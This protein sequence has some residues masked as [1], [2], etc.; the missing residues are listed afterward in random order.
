MCRNE[1]C[2]NLTACPDD[3]AGGGHVSLPR[4]FVEQTAATAAERDDDDPHTQPDQVRDNAVGEALILETKDF[5][6]AYGDLLKNLTARHG[7]L[8]RQLPGYCRPSPEIKDLAL[9]QV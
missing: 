6:L 5:R 4:G 7:L 9:A 1:G 3:E 8:A 2:S